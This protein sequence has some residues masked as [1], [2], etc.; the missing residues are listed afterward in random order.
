MRSLM[1]ITAFVIIGLVIAHILRFAADR[2]DPPENFWRYE[3]LGVRNVAAD[4]RMDT[5]EVIGIGNSHAGAFDFSEMNT[6]GVSIIRAGGD[7]KEMQM[8]I[9]HWIP[10]AP[11]VTTVLHTISPYALHVD[12]GTMA[13]NRDNRI[14]F[15]TNNPIWRPIAGDVENFVLGKV[16]IVFPH[17]QIIRSDAWET[18]VRS[19]VSQSLSDQPPPVDDPVGDVLN[20]PTGRRDECLSLSHDELETLS[21]ARVASHRTLID[22]S[23]VSRVAEQFDVLVETSRV[24]KSRGIRLVF[25]TPPYHDTFNSE[26]ERVMP[27][28]VSEVHMLMHRLVDEESVEYYDYSDDLR[29]TDDDS[30][31][32]D[33]DHL[34]ACGAESF[35][36]ALASEL[37]LGVSR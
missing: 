36:R 27:E 30:A 18:P 28:I 7:V 15:Y 5:T 11:R 13:P 8:S 16:Q 31:F 35:S 17:L 22:L 24:L 10:R 2:F 6:N 21:I 32:A 26:F 12:N 29:W 14:I 9:S 3:R 23:D 34:N 25:V 33:S 4:D 1:Q 37:Q 20:R 19:L